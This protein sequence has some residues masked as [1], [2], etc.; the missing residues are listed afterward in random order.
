MLSGIDSLLIGHK[1]LENEEGYSNQKKILRGLDLELMD[2]DGL[3]VLFALA[4]Q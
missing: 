3:F 2:N 4:E 1:A